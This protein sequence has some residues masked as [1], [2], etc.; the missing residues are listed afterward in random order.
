MPVT[1][2]MK[3]KFIALMNGSFLSD[4]E[5]EFLEEKFGLDGRSLL[6]PSI[7][8]D[9]LRG[10]PNRNHVK[11]SLD[12]LQ[13]NPFTSTKPVGLVKFGQMNE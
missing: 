3:V 6:K 2:I 8:D 12:I 10:N 13:I 11:S 4:A 9:V 5:L 1:Y 7:G